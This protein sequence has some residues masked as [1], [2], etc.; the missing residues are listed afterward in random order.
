MMS[1][2]AKKVHAA[3]E[4]L[5]AT[6]ERIDQIPPHELTLE[7]RLTLWAYLERL[8]LTLSDA[9]QRGQRAS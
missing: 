2:E 8:R 1:R 5:D 6:L 3:F 9:V 4:K 7:E